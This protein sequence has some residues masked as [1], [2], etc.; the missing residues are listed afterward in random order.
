MTKKYQLAVVIMRA[1]LPTLAHF[2]MLKKAQSV[3]HRTLVLL[4]S[5]NLAPSFRNPFGFEARRHMIQAG[6]SPSDIMHTHFSPLPD[7]PT[8]FEWEASVLES[9]AAAKKALGVD[10]VT[11]VAH[12]KD[13]SS[14]YVRNFPQLPLT[15]T[16]KFGDVNATDARKALFSGDMEKL[17]TLTKPKVVRILEREYVGTPAFTKIQ[18]E[19]QAVEDFQKPYKD[20]PYGINFLTGDALVICGSHILLIE[21]SGNVGTGLWALPGGFKE[22]GE[23]VE[24]TIERELFE[25]T[26]IDVPARALRQGYKGCDKFWASGRD[27]R[28]DFT[29]F[30][31]VYII[32]PN[33]DGTMP[34]VRGAS[35]AKRAEWKHIAEVRKMS[36]ELFADHAMIIETQMRRY[37]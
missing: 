17:A 7:A 10:S 37:V 3:A 8:D 29:T 21:R 36:R 2:A 26:V 27:P 34:K 22:P 13:E 18:K 4:G 14:Y 16:E 20:L 28:G 19:I 5:T 15:E 6:L 9:I 11:L 31:G 32:E 24:R 30:C 12:E 33:K 35:D 1:Q 23:K 25:E